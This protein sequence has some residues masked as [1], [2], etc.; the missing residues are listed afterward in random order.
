MEGGDRPMTFAELRIDI[1]ILVCATSAGV[2]GALVKD[3]LREGTGAGVGFVVATVLLAVVALILTHNQAPFVVGGT[4]VIL[5]GLIVSYALVITTGV[6]VLH[7]DVEAVNGLALFS[8]TIEVLGL[9]TATSL[10]R[11]PS[12]TPPIQPEGT[13]T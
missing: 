11:R 3:H 7:P 2:H 12:F 8:K 1:V 13:L 6:P 5:A 10:I 4:A 9:V